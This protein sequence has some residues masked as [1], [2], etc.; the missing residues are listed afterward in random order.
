MI[1]EEV[2]NTLVIQGGARGWAVIEPADVFELIL[3]EEYGKLSADILK[4]SFD[5]I[6][7]LWRKDL[8]LKFNLENI[9]KLNIIIGATF[10]HLMKSDQESFRIAHDI[11]ILPQY[12]LATTV[13]DFMKFA[14]QDYELSLFFNFSK[15]L[16]KEYIDRR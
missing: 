1:P 6:S 16:F 2:Y 15:H 3:S 8:P 14:G 11:A 5:Q 4:K 9:T 12:D 10:P 13:D 7:Q